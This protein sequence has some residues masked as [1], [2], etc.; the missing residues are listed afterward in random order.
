MET[1]SNMHALYR[2]IEGTSDINNDDCCT[3]D[4]LS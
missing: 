2:Y 1:L 4:Y 3:T